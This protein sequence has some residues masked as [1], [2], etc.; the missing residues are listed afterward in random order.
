MLYTKAGRMSSQL[1]LSMLQHC[2]KIATLGAGGTN[3]QTH[4]STKEQIEVGSSNRG[5][6]KQNL[7]RAALRQ[8]AES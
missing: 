5:P 6:K 2:I 3:Q 8:L 7:I 1:P 4:W